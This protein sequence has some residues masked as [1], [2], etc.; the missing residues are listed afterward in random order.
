MRALHFAAKTLRAIRETA[1][2]AATLE[3][4]PIKKVH[5][6]VAILLTGQWRTFVCNKDWIMYLCEFIVICWQLYLQWWSELVNEQLEQWIYPYL[7]SY[8]QIYFSFIEHCFQIRHNRSARCHYSVLLLGC[9]FTHGFWCDLCHS[10]DIY[11]VSSQFY[12]ITMIHYEEQLLDRVRLYIHLRINIEYLS[13]VWKLTIGR[14]IKPLLCYKS[15]H[16]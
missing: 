9:C 2:I 12:S 4:V 6:Q 1:R 14:V 10:F 3:S 8:C 13:I 7:S 15:F 16:N 5:D 11:D